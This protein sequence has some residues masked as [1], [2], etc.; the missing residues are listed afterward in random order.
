MM[1]KSCAIFAS[2]RLTDGRT[3]RKFIVADHH[4]RWS[5][6]IDQRQRLGCLAARDHG[7]SAWWAYAYPI[8]Q[9]W[10]NP[11]S[12]GYI[13]GS[14]S[15]NAQKQLT[16]IKGEL[17]NNPM[18]AD[19]LPSKK[20][21]WSESKIRLANGSYIYARGVTSRLRGGHPLWL[22][23]DDILSEENAYSPAVRRKTA[24]YFFA[25]ISSMPHLKF[26]QLVLVG[27]PLSQG[28]I[29]SE[30]ENNPEYLFL[31]FP[32]LD[33]LGNALWPERYS[34]E[35][36]EAKRRE[37]GPVRF[38]REMLLIPVSDETSLYPYNL[39][40]G[41]PV[42]QMTLKLGMDRAFWNQ[43]GVTTF[44]GVD[45]GLSATAGSDFTVI[46]IMA[47]DSVGNRWIRDIVRE[48]GL[49]Y[50][51]QL[52]LINTHA[53]KND[54]AFGYVEANQAQRIFGDM[55]ITETDL[56]IHKYTTGAEKHSLERGIPSIR[57]LLENQKYRIP[58]GDA[59]SVELTD[60]WI[61]E[62]HNMVFSEGKVETVGNHDDL[63][64]G[65]WLCENAIRDGSKFSFAFSE[66][67]GDKEAYDEVMKGV[68]PQPVAGPKQIAAKKDGE[69]ETEAEDEDPLGMNDYENFGRTPGAPTGLDILGRY[70]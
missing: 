42:E 28:D 9:A 55:I 41:P 58:R 57:I 53:K 5:E 13:I 52:S 8:W 48:R 11:G 65:N 27:T 15:T 32:A 51:V 54:V 40:R 60:L 30:V 63:P 66:Q 45:F 22:V 69:E 61:E 3:G 33:K 12:E 7:K 4:K 64:L 67:P 2:A 10:R 20:Q 35:L 47:V 1:R 16:W 34:K 44:M 56:P 49:D 50:R 43:L 39:F 36:L 29:F 23:A 6:M 24:D 26:G 37:I 25:S 70:R 68:I 21:F 17:E 19:L 59:H 31:K 62:M 14:S 38:A 46:W 18:L